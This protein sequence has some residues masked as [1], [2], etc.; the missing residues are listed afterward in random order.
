MRVAVS[1]LLFS[2]LLLA[3]CTETAP[4]TLSSSELKLG[5][6]LG[7]VRTQPPELNLDVQLINDGPDDVSVDRLAYSGDDF[8]SIT[9]IKITGPNNTEWKGGAPQARRGPGPYGG[10]DF[11]ECTDYQEIRAGQQVSTSIMLNLTGRMD[12]VKGNDYEIRI[13]Y[14]C[15]CL[16]ATWRG[17]L[18]GNTT[19]TAP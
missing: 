5:V 10:A 17:T 7:T 9:E 3:G 16:K 19:F 15:P 14:S 11:P 2:L 4:A 12:L 18:Y 8:P 1:A 13:Q 6:F